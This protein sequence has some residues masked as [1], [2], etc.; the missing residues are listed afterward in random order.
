MRSGVL[1]GIFFAT[2]LAAATPDPALPRYE[3]RA[4]MPP[5]V[6]GYLTATGA[7]AIVGYN[8]MAEMIG[9]PCR[10]GLTA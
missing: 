1:A 5:K 4:V 6:A 9:A 2:T 7:I 8:D 3:P 10:T